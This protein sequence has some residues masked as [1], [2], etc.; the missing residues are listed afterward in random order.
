V[1]VAVNMLVVPVTALVV[2]EELAVID[3][4]EGSVEVMRAELSRIDVDVAAEVWGVVEGS[5]ILEAGVVDVKRPT[6]VPKEKKFVKKSKT[7][8]PL[9]LIKSLSGH[10]MPF[11]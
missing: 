1:T 5:R 10:W 6:R 8:Y 7:K 3:S 2:V 4:V 11:H 9:R